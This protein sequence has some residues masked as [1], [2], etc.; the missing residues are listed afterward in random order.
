[1]ALC[2]VAYRLEAALSINNG[3]RLNLTYGLMVRASF[4][5]YSLLRLPPRMSAPS[6]VSEPALQVQ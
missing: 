6:P 4:A 1:M 2:A 3:N 5:I